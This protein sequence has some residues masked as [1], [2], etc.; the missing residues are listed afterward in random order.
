MAFWEEKKTPVQNIA[1]IS[2]FAAVSVVFSLIAAFLPLGSLILMVFLP[3][4]GALVA[5][6]AKGRYVIVYAFAALGLSFAVTAWNIQNTLFYTFPSL[7]VGL[8][9]GFFSKKGLPASLLTLLSAFFYMGIV[10]ALSPLSRFLYGLTP[11][12]LLYEL[13]GL[14]Q[15]P[16]KDA[17]S[18]T[19]ILA[20]SFLASV[21]ASFIIQEEFE[22]IG[23]IFADETKTELVFPILTFVFGITALV[24]AFYLPSLSYI[25][26]LIALYA[27]VLSFLPILRAGRKW[28]YLLLGALLLASLFLMAFFYTSFPYE[29][30]LST[31][32]FYFF[33]LGIGG[34]I[35]GIILR[36][37]EKTC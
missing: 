7:L 29:T 4:T 28:L 21:T 9:I 25:S 14:A 11:L 13:T 8:F 36:L 31:L 37:G 2:V 5:L 32:C 22:K 17:L 24:S 16:L 18:P 23:A 12:S 6:L 3:T 30:A 26:I 27:G 34:L 19:I 15:N 20:Y 1:F 10:Y 33:S 35:G